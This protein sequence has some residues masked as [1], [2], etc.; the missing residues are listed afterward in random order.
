MAL[1]NILVHLDAGPRTAERLRLAG[2][3]AARNGARLTGIFAQRASAHR[4]GVIATWPPE[5][6]TAAAEASRA[7]F[8]AATLGNPKAEWIDLNRGSDEQVTQLTIELA[9][10]FD[11]TIV[12][13]DEAE[14]PRTVPAN[15]IEELILE[16]GRPVL[17]VPYIARNAE[18]GRRPLIAWNNSR[19]AARALNDS[20]ALLSPGC[21]ATLVAL[22]SPDAAA[23]S[24]DRI[25]THLVSHGVA[26]RAETLPIQGIGTMD[27]LLSH[28]ADLGS[29]LIVA[30]AFGSSGFANLGRGA[31][32]RFL[33]QHMTVPVLF[34]H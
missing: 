9:R 32:T 5:E 11:L 22:A 27:M 15:F 10:A 7:A 16:S 30:G 23:P 17:V 4:V 18:I 34:S 28:A 26:T 13:Q 19:V 2:A 1:H 14:A 8:A 6:Y 24:S 25:V 20:L 21:E 31:G 29:D 33:L 12:G 3:L